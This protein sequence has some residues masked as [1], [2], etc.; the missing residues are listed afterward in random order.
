[1]YSIIRGTTR[2][3]PDA[4]AFVETLNDIA[5]SKTPECSLFVPGPEIVVSR[6][7]GRLDIMGGIADYSGSLVL[8]LPITEATFAAVQRD[9]SRRLT[10]VSLTQ[11]RSEP[12]RF[13]IE[14]SDLEHHGAPV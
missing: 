5:E 13:E 6:A 2:D 14:L 7:P 3:L 4:S 9:P 1:M 8:E 11:D 12:L 10:I